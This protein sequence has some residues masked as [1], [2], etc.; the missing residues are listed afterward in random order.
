MKKKAA[1]EDRR[2]D[3][4]LAILLFVAGFFGHQGTA[5]AIQH[6]TWPRATY[7]TVVARP[8]DTV[9][10]LSAR[11]RVPA[12]KVE[13]LNDLK[14]TDRILAG[15]PLRIPAIA[16]TTREAV[17]S[18][19]L[20]R[21]ALNYAEPPKSPVFRSYPVRRS[22][23]GTTMDA[24]VW[25]P[26]LEKNL[27]QAKPAV[28]LQF[29]WPIAGPVIS[30]FGS[31]ERGTRN[32]GINI[33]AES[34]APF[35][36]AA[37]GTVSYVGQLRGYGNLILI[38]HPHGYVTAY[39]HAENIAVTRDDHVGR[40]EVIGRAG[41]TGGVGRPQLHFEIRRGTK[42]IDPSLLLAASS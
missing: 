18:E 38:S 5:A 42:A 27:A 25:P 37:G 35:R 32:D 11:Y 23:I 6:L 8:G 16:R 19:A 22:T 26:R 2:W 29:S 14:S 13:K 7:Y 20:D 36:A 24:A 31:G 21:S 4:A 34:G 9:G 10:S 40:G 3:G 39:A 33:A 28:L 17:L 12:S 30:A 41:S 1:N 15:R